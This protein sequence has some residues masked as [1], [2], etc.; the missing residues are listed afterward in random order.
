MN[1]QNLLTQLKNV[2]A[3]LKMDNGRLSVAA[4]KGVLTKELH[5][6]LKEH[7][8]E[9]LDRLSIH[10]NESDTLA[11]LHQIEANREEMYSTYPLSDLQTGFLVG[12]S[13]FMEYHVRPHYYMELTY[14]RLD[15]ERYEVAWHKALL[16]HLGSISVVT[17]EANLK[18]L[19]N[20]PPMNFT[21]HDLRELPR[22]VVEERLL[23]I[24]ERI[25]REE[26]PLDKWPWF[27]LEI[28]MINQDIARVHFN[29]N[30]FF[31]D[32]P[33]TQKLL[34][35]VDLLYQ[36]PNRQLPKI[37]ITFR[38]CV[39][40]LEY[41][42]RGELG[43][44]S[45]KYWM[46]RIPKL[47]SPPAVPNIKNDERCKRS[48]MNRRVS[49]HNADIWKSFK[50]N[51]VKLGLTP[52]A[53]I[54]AV[55]VEI[56]AYWSNSVH[57]IINNM[58]THRF[59]LHPH[60]KQVIGN[61]ASLYPLEI[62]HR[63]SRSFIERAQRLKDQLVADMKHLYWPGMKVMQ[64]YNRLHGYPG[65]APCPY[66]NGSGLFMAPV[67][68]E[69]YR[70]LETPQ[71]LLDHQYW[72]LEDGGLYIV[73]DVLEEYYPENLIDHM[74]EKYN[75]LL[76]NLADD[77]EYWYES[78]L[79]SLP[80]QQEI[81]RIEVN[82]TTKPASNMGLHEPIR[83]SAFEY[84]ERIAVS[85]PKEKIS[86]AELY[87]KANAIGYALSKICTQ[88]DQLIPVIYK[89]GVN[90]IVAMVAILESGA[91]YVPIDTDLPDERLSY[92][93][94]NT[95]AKIAITEKEFL[96]S[97]LWPK[98]IKILC[99][100]NF[101]TK[102]FSR[103][104]TTSRSFERALAYV[105][106]TSGSTGK[107][108]GV[109]IEHKSA[110]NTIL[111]INQ[112]FNVGS[113]DKVFG[114]S[115][116]SFD[117]SVYDVFGALAAG[118]TLVLP[119]ETESHAPGRWLSIM[120]ENRVTIWNS[121][122]AL[123]QLMVDEQEATSTILPDL[124][125][126]L[127]S[128]DW[129][130]L[131]L[132]ER[133][134]KVSPNAEVISLGGATEAS[135]WSI[136]YKINAIQAEWQ[137]IPYGKPLSNQGWKVLSDNHSECPD[138]VPGSLYIS[139]VGLARGYWD[140]PRKTE[141]SFIIDPKTNIR[142]YKTGDM[143]RYLPDGNIEFLGR[144]DFQVKIQGFRVELGE[145]E[146]NL[147]LHENVKEVVVLAEGENGPG[148]R[149]VAYVV[150][151]NYVEDINNEEIYR[152]FLKKKLPPYMVP[153]VIISLKE[154]PITANGKIDRKSLLSYSVAKNHIHVEAKMQIAPRN[155]TEESLVKIWEDLLDI[156]PIGVR[157]DFFGL[158]GQ[159]FTAVRMLAKI[160]QEFGKMLNLATI[161]E[162]RT[163]ESLAD[164][165]KN[166][167]EENP[168]KISP[169]VKIRTNVRGTPIFFV[170]PAG[171]NVL[172]Y[173]EL[174]G[175]LRH[176]FYGLQAIGLDGKQKPIT[177]IERMA[178][179]YLKAIMEKHQVEPCILG[180]W[181]SGGIIAFEIARR[182]EDIGRNVKCVIQLDSPAPLLHGE[183]SN[184]RL[185]LWFLEDL[186]E[187]IPIDRF[188]I[189]EL[190][191]VGPAKQ[192]S[193]LIDEIGGLKSG[194]TSTALSPVFEVFKA[195][196]LATRKYMAGQI[197]S[198]ILVIKAL[199]GRV[200]EF[201]QHPALED[202]DWG[203]SSF[204]RGK[205]I[206]YSV[207][208]SHYTVLSQKNMRFIA[209]KIMERIGE[210]DEGRSTGE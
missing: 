202:P 91:A 183:V 208:G 11:L 160:D 195:V 177:S 10:D 78:Q 193:Y 101:D 29:N 75:G 82:E 71:T 194:L 39:L 88:Q 84:G 155:S 171:G 56:L 108:K 76:R 192:L 185:A 138:W 99:Q 44:R 81:K 89:K 45:K 126:V 64:E 98:D 50:A 188:T 145:I 207:Q 33:G 19:D 186:N 94:Y 86:F 197:D 97:K 48:K 6:A 143:G 161:L 95:Q 149:L 7:K 13:S 40:A 172:C 127:L 130:P 58:V 141:E 168:K 15:V 42:E 65:K 157:D 5:R 34:A 190:E 189:E 163:I 53:A 73:W 12:D 57:F 3:K 43:E 154:L 133:I 158:G 70:W 179:I 60:I 35:T 118:A 201:M 148:K 106:Y 1:I 32:G 105:I 17:K 61:F 85:T 164:K 187:E 159:S 49:V 41:L 62:D 169:L 23:E 22:K 116:Y 206:N 100:E 167:C 87:Q 77:D 199:D 16:R 21:V 131:N 174:A 110:L 96:R 79:I 102:K 14:K 203:W 9:L 120:K 125:L 111:D 109:M 129:I 173:R 20:I 182:M 135:I 51:A 69:G 83:Q 27:G 26:L 54:T 104:E 31:S 204:T 170:H 8:R 124:R 36:D 123:M 72:E 162:G 18:P 191:R 59:P 176:P 210:K 80:V 38:D 181:S 153:P 113:D 198:D 128:G 4:P 152:T 205:V 115:S 121:V 24:R 139:G 112:R 200:S 103:S 119:D 66:V 166:D 107:P 28:S 196:V 93:L 74:L 30:N 147:L 178:D 136:F 165:L 156:H 184:G 140:N 142:L 146:A 37:E 47:P 92:L 122:P 137:S 180:G 46:D 63:D 90:Q 2:G 55:Y 175:Y 67:T 134:K 209:D 132:P 68:K 114:I 151:Q 52:T 25:K 150:P 144:K 117:L